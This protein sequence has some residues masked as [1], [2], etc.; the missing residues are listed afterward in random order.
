MIPIPGT[1][2]GRAGVWLVTAETAAALLEALLGDEVHNLLSS[3]APGIIA[4]G[5]NW[6]RAQAVELVRR[7]DVRVAPQ[8]LCP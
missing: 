8:P 5:A 7:A 4:C 2:E 3:G 6:T 1:R